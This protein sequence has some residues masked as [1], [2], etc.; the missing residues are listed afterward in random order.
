MRLPLKTEY[1]CQVLAQLALTYSTEAV[2]Q[3]EDLAAKEALSP[4]YLVQILTALRQAGLVVS[5][6]GKNGGYLL[7]RHP[8]EIT[9]DEIAIAMEGDRLVESSPGNGGMSAG[10]VH[11]AWLKVNEGMM[12]SCREIKLSELLPAPSENPGGDWMI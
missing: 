6:R 10:S 1:A 4:N 7:A 8:D 11:A 12:D 5:R 2:R 9:L 3:V